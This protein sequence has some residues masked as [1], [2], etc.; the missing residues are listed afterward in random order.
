MRVTIPVPPIV[1]TTLSR[2]ED[3]LTESVVRSDLKWRGFWASFHSSRAA[4]L[5]LLTATG[6]VTLVFV[7]ACPPP[8]PPPVPIDALD[9]C[10][11][12][13]TTFASWFQS[14][15]VSLNGVVNPANSLIN[16]APDCGFYAW[17]EQMF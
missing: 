16:L 17:S 12:S 1:K 14:G 7:A 6:L 11:L 15:S 8:T 5:T 10:P 9:A 2:A 4:G 3:E 13:A